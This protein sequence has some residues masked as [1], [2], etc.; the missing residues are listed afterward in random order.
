M[1]TPIQSPGQALTPTRAQSARPK[2]VTFPAISHRNPLIS[3][4]I[5]PTVASLPETRALRSALP[6]KA[7]PSRNRPPCSREARKYCVSPVKMIRKSLEI[8]LGIFIRCAERQFM[9]TTFC[10]FTPILNLADLRV[11]RGEALLAVTFAQT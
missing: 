8:R 2:R 3:R 10:S 4:E 5:P 6:R 11:A 7:R 1:K 9:G